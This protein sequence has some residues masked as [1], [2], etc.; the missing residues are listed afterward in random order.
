MK[1][2]IWEKT[3][4]EEAKTW[5]IEDP[6]AR[7]EKVERER[8]RYPKLI[9]DLNLHYLNFED[10]KVVEIGSG[11]IS[12]LSCLKVMEKTAIDPL[13]DEYKK[14][15]RLAEDIDWL[16]ACGEQHILGFAYA[17]LVLIINALDHTRDPQCV[18]K[19]AIRI[20]KPSG[21]LGIIT[22]IDNAI[23][24]P[25][26]AH[27]HNIDAYK[28]HSMVDDTF[29]TVHELK[30]GYRYGWRHYKGKVGTPAM[31][32]LGRKVTGYKDYSTITTDPR[33]KRPTTTSCPTI[34]TTLIES[35][36]LHPIRICSFCGTRLKTHGT[37]AY[38]EDA[39]LC[40]G[41]NKVW[42][43]YLDHWVAV[44][45]LLIPLLNLRKRKEG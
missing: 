41:C 42:Y 20:L 14:F 1:T 5:N 26:P 21:Y 45:D 17:D 3:L 24:N 37:I 43:K 40:T 9:K 31:A 22:C 33:L 25:H 39:W 38:P 30:D 2:D 8:I 12:V 4:V 29:E 35:T 19:E 15:H 7:A 10:K 23:H 6:V 44:G 32:W 11:P 27:V 34:N 36:P 16:N 13:I 18:I 28:L